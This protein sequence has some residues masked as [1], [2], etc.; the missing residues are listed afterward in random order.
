MGISIPANKELYKSIGDKAITFSKEIK[1]AANTINGR[2][3]Q[4][5]GNDNGIAVAAALSTTVVGVLARDYTNQNH[6]EA[7]RTTTHAV[8][9]VVELIDDGYVV[10]TAEGAIGQG[11]KVV[12]GVAGQPRQFNSASHNADQVLGKAITTTTAAD[13]EII[14]KLF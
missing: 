8:N 2:F 5:S 4:R 13:E 11:R 14:I 12:S 6:A 9:E 7:D 1:V 3:M 10:I